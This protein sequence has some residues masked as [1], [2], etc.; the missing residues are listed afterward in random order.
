MV[1][2][3]AC[4]EGGSGTILIAEALLLEDPQLVGPVVSVLDLQ[5]R[6]PAQPCLFEASGYQLLHGISMLL[7]GGGPRVCSFTDAQLKWGST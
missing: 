5:V 4:G 3:A 2:K 1:R 7:A 6:G